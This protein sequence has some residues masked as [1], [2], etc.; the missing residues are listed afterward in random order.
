MSYIVLNEAQ[1]RVVSQANCDVQVRDKDGNHLGYITRGFTAEDIR[2]ARERS[3]SNVPCL[4]TAEVLDR[5][6]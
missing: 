1:S 5:L 3:E 2:I 6:R 4:S